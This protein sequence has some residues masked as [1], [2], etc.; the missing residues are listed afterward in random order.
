MDRDVSCIRKNLIQDTTG[1]GP[2]A[3]RAAITS[4]GYTRATVRLASVYG[5]TR[6]FSPP[7]A[8]FADLES[9]KALTQLIDKET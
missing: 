8:G 9:E 2:T 5:E 1:F 6:D 7:M 4:R 3:K